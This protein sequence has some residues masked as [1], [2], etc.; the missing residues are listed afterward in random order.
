MTYRQTGV[1][2]KRRSSVAQMVM[3]K[4]SS[5]EHDNLNLVA[6]LRCSR[7]AARLLIVMVGVVLAVVS[8]WALMLSNHSLSGLSDEDHSTIILTKTTTPPDHGVSDDFLL[9][10]YT[11]T[12]ATSTVIS[13]DSK[14]AARVRRVLGESIVDAERAIERV[15]Q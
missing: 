10:T 1:I 8:H 11:T 6:E 5:P 14:V 13:D 4:G 3:S 7:S 12:L 9:T 2:E 15:L